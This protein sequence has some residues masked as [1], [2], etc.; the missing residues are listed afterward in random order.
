MAPVES[1]LLDNKI[2]S[3]RGGSGHRQAVVFFGINALLKRLDKTS[4]PGRY[5]RQ[6]AKLLPGHKFTT[7]GYAGS[8]FE[9][10]VADMAAVIPTPPDI[11]LG[12]SFGG[13]V[14][15]RFA[16]EHP[17]LVKR[18]VLLA[19]AHRFSP[20]GRRTMDRQF[21]T[22]EKG[23]IQTCIQENSLLFRRPAYNWLVKIKLWKDGNRLASEFRDPAAILHDY[24]QLFGPEF[25]KNAAYA[26]RI[27]CPPLVIAAAGQFFDPAAFEATRRK[28]PP[29]RKR[30]AHAAP[31][32]LSPSGA[33]N[34]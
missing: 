23:D 1:G 31:G 29:L 24:R 10:I 18:L 5:A 2:P 34:L 14:A 6:V 15:M 20:G 27:A 19:S 4:N 21:E 17:R 8:N 11:V 22:L 7:L 3:I 16:A 30:N 26:R 25:D 32:K 13:F 28:N 9:E 33:Q 12:I